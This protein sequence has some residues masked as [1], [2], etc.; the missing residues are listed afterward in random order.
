MILHIAKAH[1]LELDLNQM[2]NKL[3]NFAAF[4]LLLL[5]LAGCTPKNTPTPEP[6]A[7]ATATPTIEA[8]PSATPTASP[9]ATPKSTKTAAPKSSTQSSA[10]VDC[11]GPDG[12]AIKLTQK[13]CDDFRKAWNLGTPT[14]TPAPQVTGC[15]AYNPTGPLGTARVTVAIESG[16]SWVG[17]AGIDFSQKYTECRGNGQDITYSDVINGPWTHDFGGLRPGPYKMQ[18][19]YHGK[20]WSSDVNVNGGTTNV[21]ITVSNN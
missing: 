7:A 16:Q 15:A 18:V 13:A 11:I 12:K 9:S 3:I 5:V 20:S 14:P 10:S 4:A 19:M 8:S 2:F 17:Q 21:T 6:T 1:I